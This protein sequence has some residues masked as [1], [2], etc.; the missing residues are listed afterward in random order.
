M[1]AFNVRQHSTVAELL[2]VRR[3][4]P[5]DDRVALTELIRAAYAPHATNGLRYWATHQSV[6]DTEK[7]IARGVCLVGLLGGE[8]VATITVAPPDP[9]S[10]VSLLAQPGTW[11]FGQFAV[12]PAHKGQ[13]FGKRIHDA[14][15]RE[16]AAL[17][18]TVMALH[19][20]QPAT[21]LIA[22]Y[23]SWGYSEVGTCDWRPHTNYLSVLMSRTIVS[24]A[25][26]VGA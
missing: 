12:A 15:L 8:L 23:R 17:G 24:S 16:A 14:A 26:S 10:K 3:V 21:Q 5:I 25:E 20:A 7:R 13:G 11:S 9:A 2:Q 1:V 19:T 6:S 18:C 22:M 4:A